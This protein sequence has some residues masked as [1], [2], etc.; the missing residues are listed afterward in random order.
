MPNSMLVL[1]ARSRLPSPALLAALCA[2]K[3][4]TV[5]REVGSTS[6]LRCSVNMQ[7]L[8]PPM[9]PATN[10]PVCQVNSLIVH[11]AHCAAYFLTDASNELTFCFYPGPGSDAACTTLLQSHGIISDSQTAG[12]APQ[13][14]QTPGEGITGYDGGTPQFNC[15]SLAKFH[16]SLQSSTD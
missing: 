5:T 12:C 3:H 15:E 14:G 8:H 6:S 4:S 9:T 13:P 7:V 10:T 2:V 1:Q 11:K 16:S